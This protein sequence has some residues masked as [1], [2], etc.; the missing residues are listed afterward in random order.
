MTANHYEFI[1]SGIIIAAE[2]IAKTCP[3]RNVSLKLSYSSQPPKILIDIF[4]DLTFLLAIHGKGKKERVKK[5]KDKNK[6]RI[7]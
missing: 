5:E 2:K 6:L 1:Y 4:G 7:N 3:S